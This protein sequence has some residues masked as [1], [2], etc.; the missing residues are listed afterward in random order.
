MR[1]DPRSPAALRARV[2]SLPRAPPPPRT[3]ATAPPPRAGY[4]RRGVGWGV[5]VCEGRPPAQR[6]AAR[7]AR[8]LCCAAA[9]RALLSVARA[10][11]CVINPTR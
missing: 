6:L 8:S 7:L 2:A 4:L 10:M 5:C 9:E 3:G 1:R 11:E